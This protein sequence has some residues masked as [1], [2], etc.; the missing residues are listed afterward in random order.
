MALLKHH[1]W[2]TSRWREKLKNTPASQQT[3]LV[4][5]L[6]T[7]WADEIRREGHNRSEWHYIYW[8]FKPKG[9]PDSIQVKP[10]ARDNILIGWITNERTVKAGFQSADGAVA[11]TWLFHLAS[12]IHQPLHTAQ[13]FTAE[14]P[15]GDRGGNEICIR[16]AEGRRAINLHAF[17]DGVIISSSNV[18]HL[19]KRSSKTYRNIC[20][21]S[22]YGAFGR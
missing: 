21:T 10:P 18:S 17:W 3:E 1:P 5:M 2:Y 7:A 9:E 16:P 19:Q 20:A 14:Y 8:P 13:L 6:G 11:L 12:D 4:F 15:N 22:A